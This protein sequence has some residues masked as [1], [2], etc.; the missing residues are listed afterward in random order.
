ML[1]FCTEKLYTAHRQHRCFLCGK[2]IQEKEIYTRFCG[3]YEGEF[4][5]QCYHTECFAIINRFCDYNAEN[6][7]SH[8]AIMEWLS[9][10]NCR[11]CIHGGEDD[12]VNSVLTCPI[13]RENMK[14][15]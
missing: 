1:E 15:G 7:W 5:D 10:R 12:C 14:E 11:E 9:D 8:E 6:E 13:I 3:K 4:F 2:P